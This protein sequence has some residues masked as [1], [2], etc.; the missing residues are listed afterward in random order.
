MTEH[1]ALSIEQLEEELLSSFDKVPVF[2]PIT[3]PAA[4]IDSWMDRLEDLDKL[5]KSDISYVRWR[6]LCLDGIRICRE[7]HMYGKLK[8]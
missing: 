5:V 7:I 1:D 3:Y 2:C 4:Y 8:V 6:I